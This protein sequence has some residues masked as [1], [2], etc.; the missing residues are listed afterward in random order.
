M[1]P[2]EDG[3]HSGEPGGRAGCS[4]GCHPWHTVEP[5][6]GQTRT[7]SGGHPAGPRAEGPV[8]MNEAGANL[9]VCFQRKLV[10]KMS[11]FEQSL[12]CC[13]FQEKT[14]VQ[15]W[16]SGRR[17]S[18]R[19]FISLSKRFKQHVEEHMMSGFSWKQ[20]V[21]L[22]PCKN[23]QHKM[24]GGKRRSRRRDGEFSFHLQQKAA[25][26]LQHLPAFRTSTLKAHWGGQHCPEG[27]TWTEGSETKAERT[28]K[29]H[30]FYTLKSK[31]FSY[32]YTSCLCRVTGMTDKAENSL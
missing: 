27:N 10:N 32:I 29:N 3:G 20:G 18:G 8:L 21:L 13:C 9:S 26:Y 25:V 12:P 23:L 5:P 28:S 31:M 11:F 14:Q 24:T 22:T 2:A 19:R 1:S 7:D 15:K 30:L 4:S 6:A 16:V 17:G